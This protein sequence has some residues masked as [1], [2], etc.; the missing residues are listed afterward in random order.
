MPLSCQDGSVSFFADATTGDHV[1]LA[2]GNKKSVQ[3]KIRRMFSNFLTRPPLKPERVKGFMA[4]M[5]VVHCIL[6]PE[7]LPKLCKDL[8]SDL[9][10]KPFMGGQ[11]F[12]EQ[13]RP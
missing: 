11:T 9:K 5:C 7:D 6:L 4:T 2:A 3:R 13:V 1:S 12:G 8:A 10:N